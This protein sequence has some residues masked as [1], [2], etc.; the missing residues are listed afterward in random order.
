MFSLLE[1]AINDKYSWITFY[2]IFVE[3]TT[4]YTP[5]STSITCSVEVPAM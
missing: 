5:N 2:Y 1:D 4:Y 3:A